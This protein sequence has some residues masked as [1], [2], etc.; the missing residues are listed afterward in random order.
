[1]NQIGCI[2][3]C[4]LKK[5]ICEIYE[6]LPNSCPTKDQGKP[7]WKTKE[8]TEFYPLASLLGLSRCSLNLKL[9]NYNRC[10]SLA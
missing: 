4:L 5:R 10:C 9:C 3:D 7:N 6:K 8:E 2:L 1:M